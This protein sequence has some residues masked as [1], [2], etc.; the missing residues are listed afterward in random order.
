MYFERSVSTNFS[1]FFPIEPARI[2]MGSAF[3]TMHIEI[4]CQNY[5]LVSKVS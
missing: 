3:V 1:V 2:T 4:Y 5:V